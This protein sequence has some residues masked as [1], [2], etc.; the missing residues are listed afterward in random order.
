MSG[1]M[2]FTYK[3]LKFICTGYRTDGETGAKDERYRL[4]NAFLVKTKPTLQEANSLYKLQEP[5]AVRTLNIPMVDKPTI[6]SIEYTPL[7]H[8]EILHLFCDRNLIIEDIIDS[9]IDANHL[10]GVG[11][12][13]LGDFLKDYTYNNPENRRKRIEERERTTQRTAGVSNGADVEWSA[14]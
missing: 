6:E 5:S 8:N 10:I 1:I 13:S 14:G 12:I 9:V 11:L 2:Y 4:F 3:D 7:D